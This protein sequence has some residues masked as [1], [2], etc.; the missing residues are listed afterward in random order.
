MNEQRRTRTRT[1]LA[2][3]IRRA[4]ILDAATRLVLAAGTAGLTMEDIAR[5]AGVARGTLYLYFDSI[6]AIIAAL[7]D[8]YT[9]ALTGGLEA[10]LA[11]GGSGS[12]LRR[13][14]AFI[15]DLAAAL[16]DHRDLHHALFSGTGA[17]EAPLAE[18][19][20]APLRRFIQDGSQ[21]GEFTVPDLDL[22]TDF[23]LAGLHA[24][25]TAGLHASGT[26]A[27]AAATA[28]KLARRTLSA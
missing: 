2:P 21:T 25:L 14:D 15:S 24:V 7:Q 13:L 26:P 16:R 1:R 5:E 4:S 9:Q 22:T 23:L 10:L 11:T 3:G 6:A 19:F 20:R 28:Q 8:R 18:A 27:A 12:R 17:G